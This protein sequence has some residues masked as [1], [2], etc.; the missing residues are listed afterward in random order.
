MKSLTE[1][2]G[3]KP[4]SVPDHRKRC[5]AFFATYRLN[6]KWVPSVISE[7]FTNAEFL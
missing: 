1:P 4:L 7:S 2:T 6:P 3:E 5:D